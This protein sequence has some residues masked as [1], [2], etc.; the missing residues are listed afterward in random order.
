MFN[1]HCS[2][3][4]T[5]SMSS[6]LHLQLLTPW[7]LNCTDGT[8]S[9][10]SRLHSDLLHYADPLHT[11]LNC[12]SLLV[13]HSLTTTLYYC[14]R[15]DWIVIM[16]VRIHWL[17]EGYCNG[18]S[19]SIARQHLCKRD[20]TCKNRGMSSLLN[21]DPVNILAAANAGNSSEYIVITRSWATER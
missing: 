15:T 16:R 2:Q 10:H 5:Q 19:Q 13:A 1:N 20:Q 4:S 8:H 17:A 11:I 3:Q 21:S 18:F 7:T 12:H 6:S 9:L 14:F